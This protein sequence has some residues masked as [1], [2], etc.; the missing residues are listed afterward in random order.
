MT[1]AGAALRVLIVDDCADDAELVELEFV[2]Q[3]VA[4]ECRCVDTR[5]RLAAALE[6]F[7]PDV[8]LSDLNLPGFS[9]HD[10]IADVRQRFPHVPIVLLSGA[11]VEGEAVPAA[12]A[13]L[14]KDHLSELPALVRRLLGG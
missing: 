4:V 10:A 3:G 8:V 9:G 11:L 14:V 1:G 12:S 2:T 13:A 5:A 7:V 6:A